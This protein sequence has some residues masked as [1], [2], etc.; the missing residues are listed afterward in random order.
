[1]GVAVGK[2]AGLAV[3]K[4]AIFVGQQKVEFAMAVAVGSVAAS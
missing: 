2:T 3:V 4:L 1:M